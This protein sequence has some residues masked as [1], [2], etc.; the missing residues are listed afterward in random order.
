MKKRDRHAL[1]AST[2]WMISGIVFLIY[3]I[4][5]IVNVDVPGVE[6]LFSLLSSID[7]KYIYITAFFAVL[8]E[9]LYVIG[10]FFPGSTLVVV[11]SI[12]SQTFSPIIFALTMLAIFVAWSISGIINIVLAKYYHLKVAKLEQVD[13]YKIKDRYFTTW[14][15]AFRAN[16]EV[17]QITEGANPIRVFFSSQ[18]VKFVTCVGI[19]I[20][21]MIV[22]LFFDIKTVSNEEGVVTLF[23]LSAIC[24][25]VGGIKIRKYFKQPVENQ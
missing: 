15:P 2:V 6:Y 18:R 19:T 10:N 11:L 4:I 3:G 24:L 1:L 7:G 13:D 20:I 22:P 9:G 23:I 5:I 17:A 12:V 21:A 16:Y 25:I 8:I 14:Y